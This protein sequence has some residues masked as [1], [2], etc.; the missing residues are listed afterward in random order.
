[1]RLDEVAV[2]VRGTLDHVRSMLAERVQAKN[3][4]LHEEVDPAL[5]GQ[6]LLGDSLRLGQI[7]INFAGNAIKFT[8]RG[9]ITLH[10]RLAE[11]LGDRL[12]LR[13]EVRDTGIGVAPADQARIFDAFE[14][15]DAATTRKYGGT[16]L[17]LAICKRLAQLMGG[18]VGVTSVPGNGST[19][20]F[21][22]VLK[23]G[24]AVQTTAGRATAA[25]RRGSRILLVEDNAINQ[26]V[27]QC[28]LEDAGLTVAVADDGAAALARVQA[29]DFDLVLMD[30]QMPVMDGLEST[31]RIRELGK[32]LPIIAMTAN[33]F[34]ED[35]RK[36]AAAGMDDFI[37]KPV[38]P[39]RLNALLARW[40][41]ERPA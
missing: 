2:D 17:G 18:E 40:I 13:F 31:R 34:E 8:D 11:D 28:L 12:R 33:A 6:P 32:T 16:G 35:R 20:W 15:A 37:T 3:L 38:D 30:M 23:R 1:M 26:E 5:E 14:Q 10:V 24:Q 21:T 27:A 7:L 29:E 39:D 36:C 22:A 9:G 25:L 41:P 19:F 4:V